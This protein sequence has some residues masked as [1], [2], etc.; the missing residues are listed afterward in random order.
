MIRD[1]TAGDLE[2][3]VTLFSRS[4][5]EVA[6]RDYS[7]AQVSAWAPEPADLSAWAA[8]LSTGRVFLCE[9]KGGLAGFVRIDEGGC[10]DLLM[11]IPNFSV[12]VLP[13]S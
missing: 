11:F 5:R 12:R 4:V 7:L 1:Y 9:R 2:S 3:V 8:R 13:E 10:L 6:C